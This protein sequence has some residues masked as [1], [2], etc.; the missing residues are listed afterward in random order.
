MNFVSSLCQKV[1]IRFPRSLARSSPKAVRRFEISLGMTSPARATR[2]CSK[3]ELF[4]ALLC[5]RRTLG[6]SARYELFVDVTELDELSELESSKNFQ[7]LNERLSSPQ[8][9]LNGISLI[10]EDSSLLK[11]CSSVTRRILSLPQ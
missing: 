4:I 6:H 2:F 3:T 9:R 8:G 7:R 11:T 10:S 5:Q 1:R